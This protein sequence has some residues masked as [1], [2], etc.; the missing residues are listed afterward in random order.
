MSF[1][2]F[3]VMSHAIFCSLAFLHASRWLMCAIAAAWASGLLSLRSHTIWSE[4][5]LSLLLSANLSCRKFSKCILLRSPLAL[6][7]AKI[8]FCHVSATQNLHTLIGSTTLIYHTHKLIFEIK[9]Q[10]ALNFHLPHLLQIDLPNLNP[11]F[12]CGPVDCHN[13]KFLKHAMLLSPLMTD[14]HSNMASLIYSRV[15]FRIQKQ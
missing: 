11:S 9:L 1:L 10:V 13:L 6:F 3:L 15:S 7:S 2:L 5:F 12:L 4:V 8:I 14:D